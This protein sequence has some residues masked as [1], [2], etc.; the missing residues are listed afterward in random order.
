M[1]GLSIH[2]HDLRDVA[3]IRCAGRLVAGHGHALRCALMTQPHHAVSAIMMAGVP[4]CL[5][6]MV[7]M[8]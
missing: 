8:R 5:L 4:L 2:V 1:M 6:R 3:V 7:G